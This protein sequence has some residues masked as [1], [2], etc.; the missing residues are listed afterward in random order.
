MR[1]I[2]RLNFKQYEKDLPHQV[3]HFLRKLSRDI[4]LEYKQAMV[5]AGCEIEDL[6]ASCLDQ[7]TLDEKLGVGL[8]YKLPDGHLIKGFLEEHFALFGLLD[9]LER[10][11][12]ELSHYSH[13]SE[14]RPQVFQINQI[15][16][17]LMFYRHHQGREESHLFSMV[18]ERGL[19]GPPQ[20]LA[21]EHYQ[22]R[23]LFSSLTD[24]THQAMKIEFRL[25]YHRFRDLVESLTSLLRPHIYK[26]NG[27]LYPRSLELIS[28]EEWLTLA[29]TS[30]Q[31]FW[32][33]GENRD[34]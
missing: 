7:L 14:C 20:V 4:R 22:V 27:I 26:E 18:A 28:E 9:E 21:M 11:S 2:G 31:W 8:Y 19:Y 13:Y 25:F 17:L 33:E 3:S 6:C 10:I 15:G 34:F 32:R 5:A 16:L 29:E 23:E 1:Q 24:L 30:R 12:E